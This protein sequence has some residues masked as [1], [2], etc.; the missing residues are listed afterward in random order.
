VKA[1][2]NCE[3]TQDK[4]NYNNNPLAKKVPKELKSD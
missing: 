4:K 3:R 1:D 2:E